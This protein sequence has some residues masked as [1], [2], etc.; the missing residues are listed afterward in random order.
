VT[1]VDFSSITAV[2]M[3]KLKW[4]RAGNGFVTGVAGRGSDC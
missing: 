3:L 2:V 1:R 4:Q